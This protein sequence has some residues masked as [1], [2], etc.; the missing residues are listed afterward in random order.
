MVPVEP[1]KQV[2]PT[3]EKVG[4]D[5][6]N[7]SLLC[8]LRPNIEDPCLSAFVH[9]IN[10]I[11]P[12]TTNPHHNSIS[13]FTSKQQENAMGLFFG[14]N[15]LKADKGIDGIMRA[16]PD[17]TCPCQCSTLML[18]PLNV[19]QSSLPEFSSLV[20]STILHCN[21]SL[22]PAWVSYYSKRSITSKPLQYRYQQDE[23]K[24]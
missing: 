8:C 22:T 11:C 2:N 16:L 20:F 19:F 14:G 1:F 15:D 4:E 13:M 18:V 24:A 9:S 6:H 10:V 7:A 21:I 23:D 17:D 12:E 5:D 3:N